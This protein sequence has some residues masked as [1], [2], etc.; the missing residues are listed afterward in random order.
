MLILKTV[1]CCHL[2]ESYIRN[3]NSVLF[4]IAVLYCH[5]AE[6]IICYH[7]NLNQKERRSFMPCLYSVYLLVQSIRYIVRVLFRQE[8]STLV[9]MYCVN[10]IFL[11]RLRK[12]KY[13]ICTWLSTTPCGSFIETS[14][15]ENT[16]ISFNESLHLECCHLMLTQRKNTTLLQLVKVNVYFYKNRV[17]RAL[18]SL[19]YCIGHDFDETGLHSSVEKFQ[20]NARCYLPALFILYTNSNDWNERYLICTELFKMQQ[21]LYRSWM[22]LCSNLHLIP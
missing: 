4:K 1:P 20:V 5:L 22:S 21:D 15:R 14:P 17:I 13:R 8:I 3:R 6:S 18:K 2:A 7:L 9:I 10:C 16:P 11:K 12:A 19:W